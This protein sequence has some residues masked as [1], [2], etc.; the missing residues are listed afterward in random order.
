MLRLL[1]KRDQVGCLNIQVSQNFAE[2]WLWNS[3]SRWKTKIFRFQLQISKFASSALDF[4]P[5]LVTNHKVIFYWCNIQSW[6]WWSSSWYAMMM[7]I[8]II[9]ILSY[10]PENRVKQMTMMMMTADETLFLR[11]TKIQKEQKPRNI[12]DNFK[13][14]LLL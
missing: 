9:I 7:M 2:I 5:E 3:G 11:L 4:P 14:V 10:H 8:I 13:M 12:R 1:G 6:W